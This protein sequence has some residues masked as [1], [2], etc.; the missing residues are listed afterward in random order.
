MESISEHVRWLPP[1]PPDRPSLCAVVGEGVAAHVRH[2]G[3]DHADDACVVHV[4]P[5]RVL[6]LGDCLSASPD[7]RLTRAKALP[8]YEAVL[9]FDACLYVEGHHP[10]VTSRAEL[11]DLIAKARAAAHGHVV[12]D[13]ED[14]RSFAAAFKMGA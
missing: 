5:D 11:E 6:F 3:G 1:G 8:L 12:P 4:E 9:S 7:G 2:V 10:S 14:G 13:D